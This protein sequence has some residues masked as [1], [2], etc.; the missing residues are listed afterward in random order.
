MHQQMHWPFLLI[1]CTE[2]DCHCLFVGLRQ[3][4]RQESGEYRRIHQVFQHIAKFYNY[5]WF[6]VTA[7]VYWG[8][9]CELLPIAR[10]NPLP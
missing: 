6:I 1:A 2:A 8:F 4:S 9:G 3:R 5:E 10:N 7:A